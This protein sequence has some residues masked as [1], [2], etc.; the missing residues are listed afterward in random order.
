[1]IKVLT[2]LARRSGLTHDQFA[3]VWAD[4]TSAFAASADSCRRYVQYRLHPDRA[5]PPG[6]PQ[7]DL[8]L[9]GIEEHWLEGPAQHGATGG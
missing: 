1:M 5:W 8:Q 9:D 4:E 3:Q 6:T 2:L 7:L